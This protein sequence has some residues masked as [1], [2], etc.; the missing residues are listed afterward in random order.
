MNDG[1]AMISTYRVE[2]KIVSL[3]D[4][5]VMENKCQKASFEIDGVEFSHWDFNFRDGW[6]TRAWIA[7][8]KIDAHNCQDAYNS[9]NKRLAKLI[10]RIALISQAYIEFL[11]EPFVIHKETSDIAFF[12]Y[13]QDVNPVGLMFM[14][15]ELEALKVLLERSAIPEEFYYYWNDAVN[16]IGY[17]AKLLLMISAIEAL[18]KKN[19]GKKDW[20]LIN[21]ILKEDLVKELWGTKHNSRDGLR[22]RLVHGEYLQPSDNS[23]NYVQAIH[24]RVIEYFNTEIFKKA[25]IEINVKNPQR[26]PFGNKQGMSSFVKERQF[27]SDFNLKKLLIDFGRDHPEGVK[28]E[29][30]YDHSP[31]DY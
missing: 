1:H 8:F 4:C 18:V 27:G 23:K 19:D 24:L 12:G 5:A 10:P 25:L 17:S 20:V 28:Y 21:Q 31:S 7:V 14:E 13:V 30:V 9:F 26:H 22:H 2:Q 16:A 6:T 15:D 3:A 11:N 29:R